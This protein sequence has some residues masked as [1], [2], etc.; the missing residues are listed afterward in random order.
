M[1]LEP[2]A[3]EL[4][5]LTCC[6][7]SL[8]EKFSQRAITGLKPI[9]NRLDVGGSLITQDVFPHGVHDADFPLIK[10]RNLWAKH[11]VEVK[12]GLLFSPKQLDAVI[13]AN[14]AH[15]NKEIIQ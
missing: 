14:I 5:P 7:F 6:S 10:P 8:H 13:Q 12:G 15:K 11:A 2:F 1:A 4:V 9:T 3:R